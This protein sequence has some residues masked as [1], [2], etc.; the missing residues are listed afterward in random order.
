MAKKLLNLKNKVAQLEKEKNKRDKDNDCN[1][2]PMDTCS[3]NLF[4][5]SYSSSGDSKDKTNSNLNADSTT[6]VIDTSINQ[7]TKSKRLDMITEAVSSLSSV[8]NN[9]ND[10]QINDV[11][12]LNERN[13][14]KNT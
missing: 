2:D 5:K 3:N 11:K 1:A 14:K 8:T 7:N 4:S 6:Y 10:K 9:D 12:T 13:Q